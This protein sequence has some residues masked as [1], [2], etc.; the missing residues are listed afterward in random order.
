MLEVLIIDSYK[1]NINMLVVLI[2]DR[3]KVIFRLNNYVS[4][5]NN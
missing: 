1:L 4:S 5:I 2:I 3:Y